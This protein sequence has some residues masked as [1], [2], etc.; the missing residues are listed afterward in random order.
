MMPSFFADECFFPP[1]PSFFTSMSSMLSDPPPPP[2]A[3]QQGNSE[4]AR[5][6]A[7]D[8]IREKNQ[9]SEMQRYTSSY[10]AHAPSTRLLIAISRLLL[11]YYHHSHD[12]ETKKNKSLNCLRL[13]SR[14]DAVA[15]RLETAVRMNAVTKSMA[16]VVRGMDKGLASMDVDKISSTMDKFER[17]FED[18]DVKAAYSEFL[19]FA[20]SS[21][22]CCCS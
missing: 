14:I 9:V 3:I 11:V 20:H 10:H 1:P 22:A 6:C 13:A 19:H 4:G 16:G 2:Q 5:I 18:L 17:Q 7:Q 8:A 15:S 21:S 12:D